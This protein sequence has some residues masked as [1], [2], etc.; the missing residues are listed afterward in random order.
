MEEAN[1]CLSL[2]KSLFNLRATSLNFF[3]AQLQKNPIK[4]EVNKHALDVGSEDNVAAERK[5]Q[6]RDKTPSLGVQTIQW[7]SLLSEISANVQKTTNWR[8]QGRT[9]KLLTHQRWAA[10]RERAYHRRGKST[11][12]SSRSSAGKRLRRNTVGGHRSKRD[13]VHRAASSPAG[14][15]RG[16]HRQGFKLT[17]REPGQQALT[18]STSRP[19]QTMLFFHKTGHTIIFTI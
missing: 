19:T 12:A 2:Q 13:T 7:N 18:E 5:R 17:S 15:Q 3:K 4:C 9:L 14:R 8:S 16:R 1:T 6:T 10:Q 11:W